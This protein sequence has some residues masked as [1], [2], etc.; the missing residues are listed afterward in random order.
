MTTPPYA[1]F[2][3][4]L[5]EAYIAFSETLG[6]N[7]LDARLR[8][9]VDIRV[10]QING[11]A[12]CLDM[13]HKEAKIAG[14]RELRLYHVA[15]FAESPLFS[16]TEKAALAY[17]E[18]LTGAIDNQRVVSAREALASYFS[19]REIAELTYVIVSINGWNRLAIAYQSRPGSLDRVYGLD[20]AGLEADAA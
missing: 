9:L 10:S 1:R 15:V 17:A 2:A 13:H 14:E 19:A 8:H 20:R 3:P 18:A 4:A 16:D 12:F 7:S 5:A 6:T 11:C